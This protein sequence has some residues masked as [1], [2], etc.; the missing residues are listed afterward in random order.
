MNRLTCF[1]LRLPPKNDNK[2][3]SVTKTNLVEHAQTTLNLSFQAYELFL[4][5]ENKP[6]FAN[7]YTCQ[8]DNVFLQRINVKYGHLIFGGIRTHNLLIM[9][10]SPLTPRPMAKIINTL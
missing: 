3:A 7:I 10:S 9:S 1:C 5:F 6:L 2:Q 4:F 8:T